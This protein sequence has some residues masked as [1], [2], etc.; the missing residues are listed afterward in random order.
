MD[1]NHRCFI[2]TDLQSA[3]LA[4]RLLSLNSLLILLIKR[5]AWDSNPEAELTTTW[6]AIKRNTNY[7]YNSPY[8]N[9]PFGIRTR[10]CR[11]QSPVPYRLAKGHWLMDLQ[12]LEPRIDRLWAGCSNQ[13]ELK[14]QIKKKKTVRRRPR[15]P[16]SRY[17]YPDSMV[18]DYPYNPIHIPISSSGTHYRTSPA[19][20]LSLILCISIFKF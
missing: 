4:T 10:V 7:L 11:S 13:T 17:H 20:S 9:C 6:L 16:I 1:S 2:V 14:V 12:G 18:T 19:P 15:P 8:L 3:A 5:W